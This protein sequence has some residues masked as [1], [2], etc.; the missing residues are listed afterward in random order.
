M[1]P[2]LELTYVGDV[3]CSWCWGFAPVLDQIEQD[4]AIPL[5]TMV[6]GL[7][8]G[9]AAA[10]LDPSFRDTL[11]HHWEQVAEATDQPFDRSALDREGWV[12]DTELPAVAVVAMRE[13]NEKLT[14]PWFTR[15]QRAFYAE[16]VDVTDPAA[17][18]ALLDGFDVD[19][20]RFL[21]ALGSEAMQKAAWRDFSTA[22]AWGIHG[23]PTLLFRDGD[24]RLVITRGW[25]PADRLIP[26][27][28]TW[29]TDRYGL[30]TAGAFCSVDGI[31]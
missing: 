1:T 7:R 3:M 31:C 25:Q 24:E 21:E 30:E 14:L 20:D 16:A 23:F 11:G 12:Y 22:R 10:P 26:A 9:P 28:A 17:Y 6:G 13:L 4:F 15:L 5:V 2:D 18:P 8:P 19:R 27:L 29:L